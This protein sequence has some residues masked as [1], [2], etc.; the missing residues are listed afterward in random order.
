MAMLPGDKAA[1]KRLT[2]S[3]SLPAAPCPSRRRRPP[4][5]RRG[6]L[7]GLVTPRPRH[8]APM[9]RRRRRPRPSAAAA[10]AMA[11]A[12]DSFLVVSRSMIS[13]L[14]SIGTDGAEPS[15]LVRSVTYSRSCWRS[16]GHVS[17]D[18]DSRSDLARS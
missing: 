1:H 8:L 17:S 18:M 3:F 2:S 13:F 10:G 9:L 12:R 5:R 6:R 15:R 14:V 4:S 7:G 16:V 11:A